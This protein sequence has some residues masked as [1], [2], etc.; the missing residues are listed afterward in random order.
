MTQEQCQA[1][2]KLPSCPSCQVAYKSGATGNTS[3]QALDYAYGCDACLE[4]VVKACAVMVADK[5][6]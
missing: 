2:R 1:L 3:M 5:G 6:L 4:I